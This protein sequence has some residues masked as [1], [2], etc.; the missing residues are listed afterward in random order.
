[1]RFLLSVVLFFSITLSL[2]AQSGTITG[3]VTDTEGKPLE[4]VNVGLLDTQ[5]GSTTNKQGGIYYI[6]RA[7]GQLQTP[8][9]YSWL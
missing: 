7:A 1:M 4:A 5:I 9:K 8:G 6:F 3:T 2:N